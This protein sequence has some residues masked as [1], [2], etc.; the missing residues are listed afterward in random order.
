MSAALWRNC[1]Q[2]ISASRRDGGC[3]KL[4]AALHVAVTL[5]RLWRRLCRWRIT[6]NVFRSPH[7]DF[8]RPEN[9]AIASRLNAHPITDWK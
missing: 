7:A 2:S 4:L 3:P 6:R 9:P 1:T 5:I 8:T